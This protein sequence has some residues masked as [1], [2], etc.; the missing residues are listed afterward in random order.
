MHRYGV[1]QLPCLSIIIVYIFEQKIPEI[2]FLWLFAGETINISNNYTQK[3]PK[4]AILIFFAS[5]LLK[6]TNRYVL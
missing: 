3:N 1:N 6:V 4:V 2:Q 5:L